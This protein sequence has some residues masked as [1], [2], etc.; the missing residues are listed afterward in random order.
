VEED[1]ISA[2]FSF[3]SFSEDV[4]GVSVVEGEEEEDSDEE[5]DDC[6]E[7]EDDCD[8]DDEVEGE[9]VVDVLVVLLVVEEVVV[10]EGEELDVVLETEE[11]NENGNIKGFEFE[12]VFVFVFG[13]CCIFIW[14]KTD[15]SNSGLNIDCI[16]C[17]LD[18]N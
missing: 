7:D 1:D 12:F 11:G 6:D 8:E 15:P 18:N 4:E 2:S 5:D 16:I 10:V 13:F 17:G 9:E 3:I 14:P